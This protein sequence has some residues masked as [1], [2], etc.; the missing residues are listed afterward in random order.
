MPNYLGDS[1]NYVMA[2][3][4]QTPPAIKEIGLIINL[5]TAPYCMSGWIFKQK[6]STLED[7]GFILINNKRIPI[8]KVYL[9]K[10]I[11]TRK[12]K[13]KLRIKNWEGKD[14]KDFQLLVNGIFQAEGY[15]GGSFPFINKCYFMP[16]LQIGQNAS[17]PSIDFFV[18]CGQFLMVKCDFVF[19][20]LRLIIFILHFQVIPERLFFN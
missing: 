2:N 14:F 12:E 7:R 17:I 3:P 18:Y 13:A 9:L 16:R 19:Q 4:M 1:E 11:E 5:N 8:S 15:I 6:K 20:K 10:I